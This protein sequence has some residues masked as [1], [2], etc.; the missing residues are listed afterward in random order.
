M[1]LSINHDTLVI[2]V[3]QADLAHVIGTFYR[4]DT[5]TYFRQNLIALLDDED[6]M[7]LEDAI[8]H[9]TEYTVAGVTYA[10]K[11]ELINGYSLTFSP[12]SAWTVELQ[13]SNNNLFDV[14]NG[15]LNQN[16]VQVIPGNS[17]GL[18]K[19]PADVRPQSL[20]DYGN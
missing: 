10:R 1:A 20:M 4:M 17:A 7:V 16:N 3:P 2:T 5:E 18:I 11:I 14:E 9:N 15:I 12:D 13:G 19:D 6:H 8:S